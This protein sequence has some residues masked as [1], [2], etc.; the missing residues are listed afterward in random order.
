[1]DSRA[2]LRRRVEGRSLKWYGRPMTDAVSPLMTVDEFLVAASARDRSGV[3][4]ERAAALLAAPND[5]GRH[6]FGEA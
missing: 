3:H 5:I 6:L 2:H 4:A 1:M